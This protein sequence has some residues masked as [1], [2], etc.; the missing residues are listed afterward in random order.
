MWS[1][2]LK[3]ATATCYIPHDSQTPH[4]IA[5]FLGAICRDLNPIYCAR[6]RGRKGTNSALPRLVMPERAVAAN[7][8]S[9]RSPGTGSCPSTRPPP[10][11]NIE[12][13]LLHVAAL[14]SCRPSSPDSPTQSAHN[15]LDQLPLRTAPGH[16]RLTRHR[17]YV[18][19]STTWS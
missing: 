18:A 10:S 15:T 9:L 6:T 1:E 7:H 17:V 13:S 16:C 2:S 14:A 3:C 19:S 12:Y 8:R 4:S 11:Q 5:S